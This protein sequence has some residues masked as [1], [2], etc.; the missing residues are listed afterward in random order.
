MLKIFN[1]LTNKKEILIFNN[2]KNINLYVCGVTVSD[3]CHIGHARTFYF[4]DILVRYLNYLNY[5]CNYIRNITD[6]DNKII[7]NSYKNNISIKSL[8][9][10]MILNMNNDFK[11]LNFIKPSFEPKVSNHIKLIIF[12]IKKLIKY[13]YAYISFNGDVLFNIKKIKKYGNNILINNNINNYNN[14]DFVLWKLNLNSSVK[15]FG[16]NSPWGIGRPGWHIE[17]SIIS[18]KYLKNIDIHGGGI[19]LIFPHHENEFVLSKCLFKEK[20]SV[21]HWIHTG[22]VINN[23]GKL[24]KSKNNFFLIKD[25]LKKYNSDVIKFFLMSTHYRKNLVFDLKYLNKSKLCIKK[26]YSSLKDLDLNIC[27]SDK[28]KNLFLFKKINYYFNMYMNDDFNIPKIYCLFF[29]MVNKINILKSYGNYILASKIGVKIKYFAN[30]LGLLDK[31]NLDYFLNKK[32]SNNKRNVFINKINKFIILRNK[33][34]LLKKW[35]LADWIRNRL[36]KNNICIQDK[37]ENTNWYFN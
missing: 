9:N 21:K 31:K 24:S 15:N 22:M 16:W 35:K 36:L 13:N 14:N 29:Y 37:K 12:F 18:Y 8:S 34:R 4:F 11:K 6:I 2:T 33:A 1:T 7:F 23:I 5:K 32:I 3:Y 17:C 10:L 26:I 19:D 20:Y 30:L 27:L 25:L 28:D